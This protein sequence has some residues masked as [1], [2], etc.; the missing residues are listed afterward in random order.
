VAGRELRL[1]GRR[2]KVA[3]ELLVY[4]EHSEERRGGR[5]LNQSK[6]E[7][8]REMSIGKAGEEEGER[9]RGTP[10]IDSD[11][12]NGPKFAKILLK[13]ACI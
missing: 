12:M 4:L 5:S 11:S 3:E 9:E 2:Q 1:D 13:Y 7:K 10:G 8:E 6:R